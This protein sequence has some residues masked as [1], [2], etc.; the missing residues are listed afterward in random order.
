MSVWWVVS[1]DV[2]NYLIWRQNFWISHLRQKCGNC[3]ETAEEERNLL[4]VTTYINYKNFQ[5]M[6]SCPKFEPFKI[7]GNPISILDK[8]DFSGFCPKFNGR[9]IYSGCTPPYWEKGLQWNLSKAVNLGPTLLSTFR[10][11][12]ALDRLNLWDFDQYTNNVQ[13]R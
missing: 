4:V 1:Y 7:Y 3:F 2:M 9:R 6:P 10:Q 5:E 12:S 8:T 13:R 11:V